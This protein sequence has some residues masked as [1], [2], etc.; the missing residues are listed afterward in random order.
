MIEHEP[1]TPRHERQSCQ[2]QQVWRVARLN[3]IDPALPSDP[4]R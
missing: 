3:G 1:R 4:E 2:E